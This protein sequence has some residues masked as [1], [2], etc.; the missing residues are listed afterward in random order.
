M[1]IHE[2]VDVQAAKPIQSESVAD[3]GGGPSSTSGS[4]PFARPISGSLVGPNSSR[5]ASMASATSRLKVW[6][7]ASES[8]TTTPESRSERVYTPW[9]R[10]TSRMSCFT[11]ST[12]DVR[13]PTLESPIRVRP[14]N[15]MRLTRGGRL[16]RLR[17][18]LELCGRRRVQPPVRRPSSA[19]N[20]YHS[21]R[22]FSSA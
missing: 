17:I 2:S 5:S 9:R 4:T 16:R 18:S 15:G 1:K 19:T 20:R 11:A 3:G 7:I 21:H 13:S 14:P 22:K 8:P 12:G 10:P 6:P